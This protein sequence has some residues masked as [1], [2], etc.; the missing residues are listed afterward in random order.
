MSS[1]TRLGQV[2]AKDAK[3]PVEQPVESNEASVMA[4]EG[5]TVSDE[6]A[7]EEPPK[8]VAEYPKGLHVFFIMLALILS[9]T[10]CSLDQVSSWQCFPAI[11]T[12]P[13]S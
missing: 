10:L 4:S 13:R 5:A 3:Q 12:A 8:P 1:S 9:I 2:E 7:P 6:K 11:D